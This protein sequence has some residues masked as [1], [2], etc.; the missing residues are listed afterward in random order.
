MKKNLYIVGFLCLAFLTSENLFAQQKDFQLW[1]S[2]GISKEFNKKFTLGGQFQTRFDQNSSALGTTFGEIGAK[3][4]VADFFKTGVNYRFRTR[5]E[6]LTQRID[7]ENTLRLKLNDER[8]YFRI[9]VQ[10][11]F[12]RSAIDDDNLRLRL[13]YQHKFS[14][15]VKGYLAAEYFYGWE[16]A[17]GFRN[18]RRQR[19]TGGFEYE[20]KK[21][22]FIELFYRY[23]GDMNKPRPDQD[24]IIGVGY[25]L[26]LD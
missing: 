5:G 15:K 16:Y 8:F 20:F 17:D 22:S 21:K 13:K 12:Y 25:K 4:S 1:T 26:E 19:Y 9:L 3:Y 10:R 24:Y 7:F 23:Q 18:W 2:A 11:D 6:G 14:K